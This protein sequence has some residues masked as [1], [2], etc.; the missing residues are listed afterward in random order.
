MNF[1]LRKTDDSIKQEF[2]TIKEKWQ[3][4]GGP[5]YFLAIPFLFLLI[6]KLKFQARWNEKF[7]YKYIILFAFPLILSTGSWSIQHFVDRMFLAWYSPE[8]IAASLPSGILNFAIISIFLGTASYAGTFI[9]QYFGSRQ[10]EKIGSILWQSIYLAVIAGIFFLFLIPYAPEMFDF[11]GHDK[12]VKDLEIVY[13]KILCLGAFPQVA[14]SSIGGFFSSINKT[15]TVMWVNII[16]TVINITLDYLLIFN[17]LNLGVEG[18]EGAAIATVISV[19]CALLMYGVILLLPKYRRKFN[20][21][22]AW[23]FNPDKFKRLLKFGFPNGVQFFLDMAGFTFFILFVGKYGKESLAATSIAF[24]IST[25]AFMPMI[26]FGITISVL[27]GQNLGRN[28]SSVAERIAYSGFHLTFGYMFLISLAY[29]FKAEWF[30]APFSAFADSGSFANIAEITTVLLKF[31]ALYSIFETM[32]IIFASAIKGAGD[33][34]FVMVTMIAAS[35]GILII[36]SYLSIFVFNWSLYVSWIF[37]VFYVVT[38]GFTFFIRFR[39]SK[40]KSMRVIE[41]EEPN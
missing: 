33:T 11:I 4:K 8:S 32:S 10:Y 9:A 17:K 34:F 2:L 30:I 5:Q 21:I 38:I 39:Q 29:L 26:G 12:D 16:M 18:I 25:L 22:Q 41:T 13:F 31:I 23:K 7:G 1:L 35:T 14:A 36:P 28:K 20:T 24:N 15:V 37:T 6:A 3:R 40:W 27:V 19:F